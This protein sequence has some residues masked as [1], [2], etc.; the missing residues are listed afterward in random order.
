MSWETGRRGGSEVRGAVKGGSGSRP[1]PGRLA[2]SMPWLSSL[3][4]QLSCQE[5]AG[6]SVAAPRLGG[7][8]TGGPPPGRPTGPGAWTWRGRSPGG[9]DPAVGRR[10]GARRGPR[11]GPSS[12]SLRGARRARWR[13]AARTAAASGLGA[14]SRT[15]LGAP[16]EKRGFRP[17]FSGR[18]AALPAG[19][20]WRPTAPPSAGP[21]V[22]PGWLDPD[23]TGAP[24]WPPPGRR[25][26]AVGRGTKG[27]GARGLPGRP[28]ARV[29]LREGAGRRI[30]RS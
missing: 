14:R 5:P 19:G 17:R 4:S 18:E 25:G 20:G 13:R 29:A 30:R 12:D 6:G 15:G 28:R 26:A 27:R 16:S 3:L 23:R 11:P 9:R 2:I 22:G 7:R 1:G 8:R 24:R 21:R 10:A